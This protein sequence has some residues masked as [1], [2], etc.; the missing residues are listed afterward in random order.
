MSWILLATGALVW[1][2]LVLWLLVA[3]GRRWAG[4][5]RLDV[6]DRW[7]LVTGCD[8]GIGLGV[9]EA[10]A[11]RG[12][13]VIACTRTEEGAEQARAAGAAWAPSFDLCDAAA[14]QDVVAQVR[15][16]SGGRLWG[17]V[18]NAGVALPGFVAYL[19]DSHYQRTFDVNFFA[20]AALT[21]AL[22]DALLGDA[23]GPPGRIVF[24]SSVDGIVSLPG[25][26]AYDA[27]K[28]A[29]EAFADAL[30]V[31]LSPWDVSVS[32]INPST[33]RTPLAMG[34]FERH[35]DAWDEMA[36]LDPDGAW[37]A[38]Y[39]RAW[40]DAFIA[41]NG[42]GLER[43]AQDPRHAVDDIVHA[44]TARR[45]EPRY[46][47][48]TLAK[49][50]FRALWL[51]PER[52]SER[53]KRRFI[54]PLPEKLRAVVVAAFAAGALMAAPT[55][56]AALVPGPI[57]DFEDGTLQGWAP[58]RR[59]TV[60][61]AGGPAGSTRFL[62]VF[63]APNLAVFNDGISGVIAPSV[64]AIDVDMWRPAGESDLEMRLV[65]FGPGTNNRWTSTNAQ[66]LPGD[67]VWYELTFSI[68]EPDLTRVSGAG[69]YADLVADLDRIMFRWDPGAP[70]A[71]GT[72]GAT[73]SFGIDNVAAVPE[74]SA[75]LLLL[76][77]LALRIRGRV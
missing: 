9:V 34:F 55:A 25:N 12:A 42:P 26:A 74:P 77:A 39:S 43:I 65:L 14:R 72:S 70:S 30:R 71:D 51:L 62:E 56:S 18:H 54:E 4:R 73:G 37:Q 11:A 36:R 61:V 33:L 52:W 57:S 45:P 64:F 40:L 38:R 76:S 47:S 44:L 15:E 60:N 2:A 46:L 7:V 59:N 68:R 41:Q 50:L 17:L 24:V 49:T 67:G 35:R 6:R 5:A 66:L 21:R 53:L 19:P 10:L 13:R 20:P 63:P 75:L 16:R 69:T 22:L 28:F 48:G 29:L 32:V 8:S 23:E 3:L 27:S 1:A 58:P 31:E